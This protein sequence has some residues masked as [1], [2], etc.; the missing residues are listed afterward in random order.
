M[1]KTATDAPCSRRWQGRHALCGAVSQGVDMS[2]KRISAREA[3]ELV[4]R[5]GYVYLDVRTVGEFEAGRPAGAYNVPVAVS[6]PGGMTSNGDFVA[7]TSANFSKDTKLVVGCQSGNRSQRA[8]AMLVSAG[9][10]TVVEQRA[11]WGGAKDAFG[12]VLDKGWQSEGLPS[13]FGPDPE[14][15]YEALR[16]K[17]K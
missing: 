10:R 15:G 5:E 7:V 13:A 4:E 16:S 14:R 3:H 8:A 6:G 17:V 9:C 1:I 2:V 12:R 11:G